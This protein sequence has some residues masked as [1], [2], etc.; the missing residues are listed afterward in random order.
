MA[1]EKQSATP[2]IS[3]FPFLSILACLSATVVVMIVVL[4]IIQATQVGGRA[5]ARNP[6]AGEF[7]EIQEKL[8]AENARRESLT[9]LI[10]KNEAMQRELLEVG[11]RIIKLQLMLDGKGDSQN[12]SRAL[13]KELEM[14][15]I[16]LEELQKQKPAV[17]KQI[18]A[19]KQELAARKQKAASFAPPVIVQPGGSGV[20][21]GKHLMIVEATGDAIIVHKSKTEKLRIAA[22]TIGADKDYDGY[23]EKG[24]ADKDTLVLFLLR[25]DGWGSYLR[26]AGWAES[27]FKLATGKVP[28]P[29]KGPVDLTHFE[30]F[31]K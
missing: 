20:A 27:Q 1:R 9:V 13:Q 4:S 5:V 14:L 12:I 22:N 21:R 26:G 8:K 15:L 29:G 18:D 3:L 28:I 16:Q 11:Q 23:L 24:A 25:E 19:L 6:L 7:L 17:E 10:Q 30:K 2:N 31:M